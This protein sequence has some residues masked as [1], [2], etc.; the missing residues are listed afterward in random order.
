MLL[1]TAERCS[2]PTVLCVIRII[3][4]LKCLLMRVVYSMFP[5]V[6]VAVYVCVYAV[7]ERVKRVKGVNRA[8]R[9]RYTRIGNINFLTFF[10]F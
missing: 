10:V 3:I 9:Y 4:Q 1:K 2:F 7:C 8:K 6:R 5:N